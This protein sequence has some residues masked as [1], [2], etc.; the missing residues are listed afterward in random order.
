MGVFTD[1]DEDGRIDMLLQKN[2][3][4]KTDIVSVYNNIVKDTFFIKALMI[5]T[6]NLYG[7]TVFGASYRF[8]VTDL[9]D[10]KFVVVGS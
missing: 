6:N 4:G 10:Y 8:V 9:N 5:N 3:N 7:D 2:D 1:I